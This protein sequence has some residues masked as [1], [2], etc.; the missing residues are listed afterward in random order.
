MIASVLGRPIEAREIDADTFG[1]RVLGGA[2]PSTMGYELAAMRAISSRYSRHDFV[3]NPN[4]LTWLLGRSPTTFEQF[5]R[6][7]YAATR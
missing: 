2:D 5:V 6:A 4:V 3:G 7:E 1:A